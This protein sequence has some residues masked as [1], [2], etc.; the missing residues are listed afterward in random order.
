M[1]QVSSCRQTPGP[2]SLPSWHSTTEVVHNMGL[3]GAKALRTAVSFTAHFTPAISDSV[4][5]GIK[6]TR[7]LGV[8][9]LALHFPKIFVHS[10]NALSTSRPQERMTQIWKAVIATGKSAE[11]FSDTMHTLRIIG[12]LGATVW[13]W[14]DKILSFTF[15]LQVVSF[16]FGTLEFAKTQEFYGEFRGRIKSLQSETVKERKIK[17]ITAACNAI[18]ENK[19]RIEKTF[20]FPKSAKIDERARAVLKAVESQSETSVKD[21]EKFLKTLRQRVDTVYG[22]ELT[23]QVLTASRLTMTV[24]GM[25]T[26]PTPVSLGVA[27]AVFGVSFVHFAAGLC[28]RNGDPFTTADKW[29]QKPLHYVQQSVYK[30]ADGV[31][32][33]FK[34]VRSFA[35]AA[36]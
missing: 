17:S 30:V 33:G 6:N 27:A 11:G 5:R 19:A 12:A 18:I 32:C 1:V 34:R 28:M 16:A 22:F 9:T 23:G 24:I 7:V 21:G 4:K 14:T 26:P 8:A 3:A 31:E 35:A 20:Y 36:A 13:L 2:L 15:P 25:T 10:Y 29:H